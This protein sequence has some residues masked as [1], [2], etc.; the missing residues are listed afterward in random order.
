MIYSNEYKDKI[1]KLEQIILEYDLLSDK[2]R[3][4]IRKQIRED[5]EQREKD[6]K[7]ERQ[8]VATAEKIYNDVID[9]VQHSQSISTFSLIKRFKI[10]HTTAEY[11]I[12]KLN[13]EGLLELKYGTYWVK[14]NN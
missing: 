4:D 9:F 7:Y 1:Y 6:N 5:R 13:K 11:L 10:G 14:C 12:D 3:Q 8:T 2:E